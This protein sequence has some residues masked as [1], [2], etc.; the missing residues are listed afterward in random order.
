MNYL[1]LDVLLADHCEDNLIES[2]SIFNG[3]LI[4]EDN[5]QLLGR[6]VKNVLQRILVSKT[7]SEL[8]NNGNDNNTSSANKNGKNA[9]N[10][11]NSDD[12][13]ATNYYLSQDDKSSDRQ[14]PLSVSSSSNN[15]YSLSSST[16][17][18][19][20]ADGLHTSDAEDERSY[21]SGVDSEN[22][23]E[24]SRDMDSDI[25]A[26]AR[27]LPEEIYS[28]S[29]TT[30]KKGGIAFD[31]DY[32]TNGPLEEAPPPWLAP[33]SPLDAYFKKGY[34][35]IGDPD[36]EEVIVQLE[37]DSPFKDIQSTDNSNS[38]VIGNGRRHSP[39]FNDSSTCSLSS[40]QE[41]Q[42]DDLP[43][44]FGQPNNTNANEKKK[45]IKRVRMSEEVQSA[46]IISTSIS[47]PRSNIDRMMSTDNWS[48]MPVADIMSL[49]DS[50]ST[51]DPRQFQ[52][53]EDD[54]TFDD[55]IINESFNSGRLLSYG[56]PNSKSDDSLSSVTYT[57]PLKGDSSI[58]GRVI[59]DYNVKISGYATIDTGTNSD[60]GTDVAVITS[61]SNSKNKLH[62]SVEPSLSTDIH[63]EKKIF[64]SD[65]KSKRVKKRN[66]V[67][68]TS[69]SAKK[70]SKTKRMKS[71]SEDIE[72]LGNNSSRVVKYQAKKA[73]TNKN[74][75]KSST[76]PSNPVATHTLEQIHE[77]QLVEEATD[78]IL[79]PEFFTAAG[80]H[81]N[82]DGTLKL[83]Q[84][85]SLNKMLQESFRSHVRAY[86][87]GEE[88]EK[89]LAMV[90][91]DEELED[92][93]SERVHDHDHLDDEG[94][95]IDADIN[96]QRAISSA[97]RESEHEIDL[98]EMGMDEILDVDDDDDN[99]DLDKYRDDEYGQMRRRER[100]DESSNESSV[101]AN[102]SEFDV[103]DAS[104]RAAQ[105]K[106]DT[107]SDL[108]QR[109]K[110]IKSLNAIIQANIA[111]VPELKI[112]RGKTSTNSLT[113]QE[114]LQNES[115]SYKAGKGAN[116]SR[117]MT[118]KSQIEKIP[119]ARAKR[120]L[121]GSLSFSTKPSKSSKARLSASLPGTKNDTME[122]KPKVSE[123]VSPLYSKSA[124][125][126]SSSNAEDE[127]IKEVGKA[128]NRP[129]SAG[130]V[131]KSFNSS[132]YAPTINSLRRS[133][134][135]AEHTNSK[136]VGLSRSF[137]GSF[138]LKSSAD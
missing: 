51:E 122:L 34:G 23:N 134:G 75:N 59:D 39:A 124:L 15:R 138:H 4:D 33:K 35:G 19:D 109:E 107:T 116:K 85:P 114:Q 43:V 46:S 25:G 31:D 13:H 87:T 76:K 71:K 36:L 84:N 16:S 81:L 111:R 10:S 128:K 57:L 54:D 38:N 8:S 21:G 47:S 5:I 108:N 14:L 123:E 65:K 104:P 88:L 52:Y 22:L 135:K 41:I 86:A 89:L 45:E 3:S 64:S 30:P 103:I 49:D 78:G 83:T 93:I 50:I 115:N 29:H 48:N 11:K 7:E 9:R 74:K 67:T 100:L 119:A 126:K 120:G 102:S 66:F 130:T 20:V 97:K 91:V 55:K 98:V 37:G 60:G 70:V 53:D 61:V 96:D 129:S 82:K 62:Q 131:R 99:S 63:T 79:E 2:L 121:G 117:K 32:D 127:L 118:I 68:D 26:D 12:F 132:L 137:S 44:D 42:L 106:I 77:N 17:I 18:S 69:S 136:D 133:T 56:L 24:Y 92:I 112:R 105:Y 6:V 101:S 125:L 1:E 72:E 58:K 110:D 94:N 95:S 113:K 28:N 73:S 90:P 40:R 80:F 27:I